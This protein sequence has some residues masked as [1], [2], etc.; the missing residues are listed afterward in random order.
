M[1]KVLTSSELLRSI[2]RRAF[3]PNDQNTFSDSDFLDMLNEEISYFGIPHLLRTHE[4]YLVTFLD[5][6]VDS[7]TEQFEFDIPERAIGNKLRDVAFV[8]DNDNF[9]EL[10][11]VSLE[12]LSDYNYRGDNLNDYTEAFYIKGNKIIL[13]DSLPV[14]NGVIRQFFYL[15]PNSLVLEERAAKITSIDTNTGNVV[16]DKVPSG[17]SNLPKMDFVQSR[18]PNLILNFDITPSAINIATKTLTFTTTD[19][20]ERLKVGDYVNFAGEAVVP[21]LPSE[22]HGILAQRVAVAALEA[23]GDSQNMQLAQNRLDMME[24]S[25]NDLIDNRV[26]GA[27]QKLKNRHGTLT[28]ATL[29]YYGH[30]GR[31]RT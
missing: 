15:K 11:R 22:L 27:P 30:H 26:D 3:I 28:E 24:K 19:I 18:S 2:K 21:Q 12:D 9:Y 31:G 25:V 10:S 7:S 4:E 1:S 6:E 20:P 5:T 8:D 13:V 17:F 14:G 16:L 29:N 23:L